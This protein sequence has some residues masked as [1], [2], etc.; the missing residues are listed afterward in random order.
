MAGSAP[1]GKLVMNHTGAFDNGI[2]GASTY[3]IYDL[4]PIY[5]TE[6]RDNT[7]TGTLLAVVGGGPT[8][9][10]F[11][12]YQGAWT[13]LQSSKIRGVGHTN[14]MMAIT[15]GQSGDLFFVLGQGWYYY[16]PWTSTVNAPYLLPATGIGSGTWIWA[17][18]DG[19]LLRNA[20]T[21]PKLLD[22]LLPYW[23]LV[24]LTRQPLTVRIIYSM[25]ESWA[26]VTASDGT[27]N[28]GLTLSASGGAIQLNDRFDMDIGPFVLSN[29]AVGLV[30]Q[31]RVIVTQNSIQS[32][33]GFGPRVAVGVDLPVSFPIKY[34]NNGA[35]DISIQ[36]QAKASSAGLAQLISPQYDSTAQWGLTGRFDWLSV[37]QY[38]QF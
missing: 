13:L 9:Y 16:D 31:A 1:G 12:F 38:R 8:H 27:T 19:V 7:P 36:V 37:N 18:K 22:N 5:T 20:T 14:D 34:T 23:Q 25:T 29:S 3:D 17:N 15:G 33:Y 6:V 26:N 32:I 35:Y 10:R 2:A 21:T 30:L 28:I 11:V 4:D 24:N